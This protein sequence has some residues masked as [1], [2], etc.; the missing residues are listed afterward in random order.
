MRV[1]LPLVVG[2]VWEA[3]TEQ[4]AR[5]Y[6]QLPQTKFGDFPALTEGRVKRSYPE[7]NRFLRYLNFRTY[8]HSLN[9][10]AFQFLIC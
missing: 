5:E 9:L 3:A 1:S 4:S 10:H 2:V 7:G 8:H 6:P